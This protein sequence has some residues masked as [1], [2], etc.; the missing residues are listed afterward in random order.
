MKRPVVRNTD[1]E[2]TNRRM[3][4]NMAA[5]TAAARRMYR[6]RPF[7]RFFESGRCVFVS[8]VLFVV[9]ASVSEGRGFV[10]VDVDVDVVA[11]GAVSGGLVVAVDVVGNEVD[12]VGDS[13]DVVGD[14][15]DVVGDGVDVVGE[16][17]DV[18]GDGVD[19]VGDEVDVVDDITPVEIVVVCDEDVVVSSE[20]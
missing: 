4:I 7:Q 9:V 20:I 6:L 5:A 8:G 10:A 1:L 13:V 3:S 15:V 14:S 19:V 17:V 16:G 18:V 12:V 11:G 2:Q